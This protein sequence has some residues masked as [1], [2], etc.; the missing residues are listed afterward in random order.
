MPQIRALQA[1]E[2]VVCS[3]FTRFSCSCSPW[4]NLGVFFLGVPCFIYQFTNRRIPGD[5]VQGR[6]W[7]LVQRRNGN[8]HLRSIGQS[9]RSTH[10]ISWQKLWKTWTSTWTSQV[11]SRTFFTA[12]LFN[13]RNE[14]VVFLAKCQ[15]PITWVQSVLRLSICNAVAALVLTSGHKPLSP[16]RMVA[17][18][19]VAV[20]IVR[21]AFADTWK[22]ESALIASAFISHTAMRQINVFWGWHQNTSVDIKSSNL[23]HIQAYVRLRMCTLH[24]CPPFG[25]RM[26]RLG[27]PMPQAFA[28]TRSLHMRQ[29]LWSLSTAKKFCRKRHV[30]SCMACT[31]SALNLKHHFH[32][33]IACLY[34]HV[35][36]FSLMDCPLQLSISCKLDFYTY[37]EITSSF[38]IK[39]IPYS[40]VFHPCHVSSSFRIMFHHFDPTFMWFLSAIPPF[41]WDRRPSNFSLPQSP[42]HWIS[43]RTMPSPTEPTDRCLWPRPQP[44]RCREPKLVKPSWSQAEAKLKP[45]H[46]SPVKIDL[47]SWKKKSW[48]T[49]FLEVD[50]VYHGFIKFEFIPHGRSNFML[51]RVKALHSDPPP[52]CHSGSTGHC[53][54]RLGDMWDGPGKSTLRTAES[55]RVYWRYR[56]V[57]EPEFDVFRSQVQPHHFFRALAPRSSHCAHTS[58]KCRSSLLMQHVPAA[59]EKQ[60]PPCLQTNRTLE[61]SI[62]KEP[63]IQAVAQITA[64]W[65]DLKSQLEPNVAWKKHVWHIWHTEWKVENWVLQ[66][67]KS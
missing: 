45:G 54:C 64:L 26:S 16:L 44:C 24:W 7:H 50:Q 40:S 63:T 47:N 12:I 46:L 9:M 57:V 23:L 28:T 62:E 36:A 48:C 55:D 58:H 42:W 6:E 49:W 13:E 60:G 31:M 4:K 34:R 65:N 38:R 18:Q 22:L 15:E 21:I 35:H 52:K 8:F 14:R 33:G 27:H 19:H 1:C 67:K 17:D 5:V 39:N 25:W 59:A 2:N 32:S 20:G 43:T 3:R 30:L 10:A 29:R 53:C 11:R 37:L 51:I 41:L 61:S 56:S 66:E